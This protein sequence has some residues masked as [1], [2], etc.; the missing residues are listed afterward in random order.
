MANDGNSAALEAED[1]GDLVSARESY[2]IAALYYG[3]AQ[4]PIDEDSAL[5][6]GA[7]RPQ[8]RGLW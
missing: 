6:T 7:Q 1:R 4:W 3:V 2:L 5:N 8:D